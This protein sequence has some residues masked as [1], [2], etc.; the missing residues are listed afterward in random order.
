[1]RKYIKKTLSQYFHLD[2]ESYY[3]SFWVY[4]LLITWRIDDFASLPT[5]V[6]WGWYE[7]YA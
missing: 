2:T 6:S 3:K 4:K 7:D 5:N 1:M